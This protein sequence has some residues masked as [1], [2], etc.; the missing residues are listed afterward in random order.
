[1][2]GPPRCSSGHDPAPA[3]RSSS[4]AGGCGLI[5]GLQRPGPTRTPSSWRSRRSP[6]REEA[7]P[8][9]SPALAPLLVDAG[10]LA[11]TLERPESGG[12]DARV[13]GRGRT[14]WPWEAIA[15]TSDRRLGELGHAAM[16]AGRLRA[17]RAGAA[18]RARTHGSGVG[19]DAIETATATDQLGMLSSSPATPTGPRA[20]LRSRH[21]S[22]SRRCGPD[23]D[24]L[25]SLWRNVGGLAHARRDL[26]RRA[27]RPPISR[28]P[29]EGARAGRT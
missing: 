22:S 5:L 2:T 19:P 8:P 14:R 21:R 25:A 20:Y 7:L 12:G 18:R 17:G 9:E 29:R 1:M 16:D 11:A 27:A 26:R 15:T 6:R 24:S 13:G 28:D 23:A 3:H 10:G 4:R